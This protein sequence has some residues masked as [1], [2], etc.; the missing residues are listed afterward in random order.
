MGICSGFWLVFM[1]FLVLCARQFHAARWKE[2]AGWSN[3]SADGRAGGGAAQQWDEQWALEEI[4]T[5]GAHMLITGQWQLYSCFSK[6]LNRK[7]KDLKKVTRHIW[8]LQKDLNHKC[9]AKH[10]QVCTGLWAGAERWKELSFWGIY[11]DL[12]PL[13]QMLHY[14]PTAREKLSQEFKRWKRVHISA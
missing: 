10:R 3:R 2:E 1:F 5:A 6:V 14:C 11:E 8:W 12:Q 9:E 7:K 13:L 4:H